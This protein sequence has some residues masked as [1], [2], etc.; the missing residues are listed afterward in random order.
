MKTPIRAGDLVIV[1]SPLHKCVAEGEGLGHIT[2]V[3]ETVFDEIYCR[4]CEYTYWGRIACLATGRSRWWPLPGLTK[5]EPN[6]EADADPTLITVPTPEE[7][8]V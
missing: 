6:A 1:T 4:E 5:I 3:T 8:L 7:T 2:R